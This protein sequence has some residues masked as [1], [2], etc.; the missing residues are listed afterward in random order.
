MPRKGAYPALAPFAEAGYRRGWVSPYE[1][2]LV[3]DYGRRISIPR[4]GW[5]AAGSLEATAEPDDREELSAED[6]AALASLMSIEE[7]TQGM[8]AWLGG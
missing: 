8:T 1:V 6:S 7:V 4:G 5:T 3:D 2:E